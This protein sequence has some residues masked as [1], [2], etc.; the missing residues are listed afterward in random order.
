MDV[1]RQPPRRQP[2]RRRVTVE[3]EVEEASGSGNYS[4]WDTVGKVEFQAD[5]ALLD[6]D[7]MGKAIATA[8]SA[9]IATPTPDIA[10]AAEPEVA[11]E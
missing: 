6:V 2:P 9:L 3:I 5:V 8:T 4:P 1:K 7:A 10:R 11:G